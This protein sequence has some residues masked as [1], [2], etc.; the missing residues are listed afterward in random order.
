MDPSPPPNPDLSELVFSSIEDAVKLIQEHGRQHGY[1]MVTR[2]SRKSKKDKTKIA[3]L[4][5]ECDR[6]TTPHIA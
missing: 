5:L 3:M 4:Y 6:H 1:A 2:R